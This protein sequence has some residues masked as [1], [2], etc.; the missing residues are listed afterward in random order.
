MG[1]RKKGEGKKYE[2]RAAKEKSL[3]TLVHAPF[4]K[5]EKAGKKQGGS[6]DREE[7]RKEG[8]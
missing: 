2:C 3:W 6:R 8:V 1:C 5:K 4:V 7:N